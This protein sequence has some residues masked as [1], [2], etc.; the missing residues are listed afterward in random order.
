M[1]QVKVNKYLFH[2]MATN[3]YSYWKI[4]KKLLQKNQNFFHRANTMRHQLQF[5]K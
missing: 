4:V 5:Q 3:I 1:M 2:I